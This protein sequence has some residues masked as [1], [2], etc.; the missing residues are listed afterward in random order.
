[1]AIMK[2]EK[3]F[4]DR[5]VSVHCFRVFVDFQQRIIRLGTS[6]PFYSMNLFDVE[7]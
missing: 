6:I 2:K 1:M 5:C 7:L 3:L 4:A